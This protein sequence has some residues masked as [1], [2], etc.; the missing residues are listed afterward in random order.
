MDKCLVLLSGGQ[1]SA[2]CL[3]WASTSFFEVHTVSFNY[4]QRH[5]IELECSEK[6]SK[7]AKA[8]SHTVVPINSFK[9]VSV[10]SLLGDEGDIDSPHKINPTLPSTFVPGR[11]I[12]FLALAG[13]L[14][15]SQGIDNIIIGVSQADYSGYPDCRAETI[16]SMETTL[17]YG[18]GVNTMVIH[19]PLMFMSKKEEIEWMMRMKKLSWYRYT[20]TCYNG[21]RPGCKECPAC[22]LR[23]RGFM[24]AGVSDPLM[25]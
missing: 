1:D 23:A 4:G 13:A 25:F 15:Y 7:L 3:A 2:T 6:L 21:V 14:A 22:V 24:E 12:V 20:H 5:L 16:D 17:N 10:T 8:K 11:N 9:T 19:T 18:L